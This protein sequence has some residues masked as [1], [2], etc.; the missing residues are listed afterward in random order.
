MTAPTEEPAG[1]G[2]VVLD[3]DGDEWRKVGEDADGG[4]W[5]CTGDDGTYRWEE[6]QGLWG[7]FRLQSV[8]AADLE[9]A[10]SIAVSLEQELAE[11]R[12][13]KLLAG[14]ADRAFGV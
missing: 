12:R 11:V 1:I 7:P 13:L 2:T 3:R 4:F 6:L 8:P 14:G 9:Q 10:R 5:V